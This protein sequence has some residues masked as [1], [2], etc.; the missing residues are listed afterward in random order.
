MQ[1]KI[2]KEIQELYPGLITLI[3][4]TDSMDNKEKQHLFDILPSMK[5]KHI[6]KLFLILTTE[7]KE[8]KELETRYQQHLDLISKN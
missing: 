6:D 8:L 1:Y 3:L 5:D 2:K 7:R 4:A